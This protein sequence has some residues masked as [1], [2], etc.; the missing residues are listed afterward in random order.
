MPINID[1]HVL[2]VLFGTL[3]PSFEEQVDGRMC[4]H[5]EGDSILI[6]KPWLNEAEDE[7]KLTELHQAIQSVFAMFPEFDQ[8]LLQPGPPR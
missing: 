1:P 8:L 4:Y 7:F 2:P 5:E 6:C 3:P